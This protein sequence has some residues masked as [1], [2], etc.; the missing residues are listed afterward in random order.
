M[1]YAWSH[2]RLDAAHNIGLTLLSSAKEWG[3]LGP[4]AKE[5][6]ADVRGPGAAERR[7]T[8]DTEGGDMHA[9]GNGRLAWAR[10]NG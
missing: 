2:T 7:R 8:R 1:H 10:T 6:P 9:P 5:T 3:K 4:L